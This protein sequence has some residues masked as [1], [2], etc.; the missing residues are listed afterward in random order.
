MS[1]GGI[2][3]N[4]VTYCF[5]KT[6]I[7]IDIVLLSSSKPLPKNVKYSIKYKQILS[8]ISVVGLVEPI[9]VYPSKSN[10][11]HFNIIDGHLRVEAF[12]EFNIPKIP[13]L[14]ATFEDTFSYNKRTARINAIH[15]H[16]MILRAVE[17]GVSMAR[18]S[19]AL[20]ISVDSIRSRFKLLDGICP[21]VVTSLSEKDIPRTVFNL[22]RKMQPLRQIEV[23]NSMINLGVY[24]Y[25]FAYSM[26]SQTPDE[27]LIKDKSKNKKSDPGK[28]EAIRKLQSELSML[29]T[30]K[31][32]LEATYAENNLQLVIIKSHVEKLLSNNKVMNWLYDNEPDYLKQLKYIAGLKSL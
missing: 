28:I 18:L 24:T 21:E 26:L 11:G 29:D 27:L 6:C 15:E 13:C 4:K 9:V 7:E 3:N 32:E 1:N 30:H 2:M 5:N 19:E 14:I 12:K 31:K 17:S 22:L 25:N 16:K 10:D 23:V 8:S 20:G